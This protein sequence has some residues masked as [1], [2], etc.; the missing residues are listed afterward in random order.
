[1][2][3]TCNLYRPC[4]TRGH[5]EPAPLSPQVVNCP[6]FYGPYVYGK[7]QTFFIRQ[8]VNPEPAPIRDVRK[9]RTGLPYPNLGSVPVLVVQTIGLEC[10][11]G[12]PE[13]FL[14]G[15]FRSA[16]SSIR[17]TAGY[18]PLALPGPMLA[19]YEQDFIPAVHHE[20]KTCSTHLGPGVVDPAAPRILGRPFPD[21]PPVRAKS[22]AV[23]VGQHVGLEPLGIQ[24]FFSLN[25]SAAS[26][27][28]ATPYLK[29]VPLA[30]VVQD[31]SGHPYARLFERFPSGRFPKALPLIDVSSRQTPLALTPAVPSL[32][33]ENLVSVIDY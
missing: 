13:C 24:A 5:S 25:L 4:R 11:T 27:P 7:A 30:L 28:S 6:F 3:K 22:Q 29:V 1:M 19:L 10:D 12:G 16:F 31:I 2:K 18:A 32:D 17:V 23:V 33:Q 26:R 9:S 21:R 15:G 20:A 14:Y 8:I